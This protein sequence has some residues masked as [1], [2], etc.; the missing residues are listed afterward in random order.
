MATFVYQGLTGLTAAMFLWLVSAGLTIAF[1]VCGILNIAHGVLYMFGGY[2]LLTFY[3]ILGLN[4]WLSLILASISVGVIG[5]IME[6][7]FFRPIY[8]EPIVIQLVL[9]FAFVWLFDDIAKLTWGPVSRS[10]A[11]PDF[12][13]GFIFVMGRP[14]PIYSLFIIIAGIAMAIIIWLL[15]DKTWWGKSIRASAIDREMA[16]AIGINIRTL[17]SGAFMFAAA[18]AALGGALSMPLRVV[19]PG[20]GGAIIVQAFVVTV[21]G[22]LGNLKGAFVGALIVGIVGAFCTLYLPVFEMFIMY[23]LMAIVLFIR[24]QGIFGEI[25]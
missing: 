1:G 9:T 8:K 16:S 18:I 12:F 19:G 22:G 14:F 3:Q 11:M 21:I 2:F 7:A 15:L 23:I 17:F 24:P 10:V 6:L 5:L 13:E 4:F 25:K 20:I